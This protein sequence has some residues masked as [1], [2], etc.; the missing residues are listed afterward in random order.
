MH[1]V[2]REIGLMEYI[3]LFIW[4]AFVLTGSLVLRPVAR[5][6]LERAK[7]SQFWPWFSAVIT[8]S[9]VERQSVVDGVQY[10]PRIR[11]LYEVQGRKYEGSQ[12]AIG[13]SGTASRRKAASLVK[14]YPVS[15]RL[16]V[17]VDPDDHTFAV[18]ETNALARAYGFVVACWLG[19]ASGVSAILWQLSIWYSATWT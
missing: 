15:R 9:E 4:G 18:L 5:K 11:F 10:V 7:G 8:S 3:F 14:K 2:G 1:G 6:N 19:I 12:I 17:A 13:Y 16:H